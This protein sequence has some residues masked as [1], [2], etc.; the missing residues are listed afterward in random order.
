[1]I[2]FWLIA[3]LLVAG[4]LAVLLRP[5]LRDTG[6]DAD[7][8]E[9]VAAMYRRQ[10]AELDAEAAQGRLDGADATAAR[11]ELM[12][13]ML[14]AAD[15]PEA[16]AAVRR[17]A[18][19]RVGAAVGIAGAVPASALAIY[20]AVGMPGAIKGA[21]DMAAHDMADLSAAAAR[22]QQHLDGDPGDV[23]GWTLLGRTLTALDRP[24]DAAEAFRHAVALAPGDPQLHAEFGQALTL[25]AKGTIT[26]E[27]AAQFAKSP[28]DPRSRYFE[29]EAAMQRGDVAAAKAGLTA[30]L[31]DTP[32][33]APWRQ[34]VATRLQQIGSGGEP[35][36]TAADAEAA[37]KMPADARL[38]MIRGM[39]GRLE[40][41]LDAHPDD[42]QGW[43]MLA[44]SYQVLGR[45]ADA[46]TALQRA[47]AD[48][49][50]NLDLMRAYLATLGDGVTG[51]QLP[52]ELVALATRVNAL[53][54]NDPPALWYL[55]LAA[56][57]RGDK[58]AATGYWRHLLAE[59]PA[60]DEAKRSLVQQRLD[61]LRWP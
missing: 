35:G 49:P 7:A 46:R 42:P 4:V 60:D 48:N 40:A 59:L 43:I 51:D 32:K 8:G 44:R 5:L 23:S 6:S 14:A 50:N 21:P 28:N 2:L 20:L 61:T 36:P 52:P 17:G 26:A 9:P 27:A 37:E 38:T 19:W 24:A 34:L 41:K 10:L 18:A 56:A 29:A 1:V 45:G 39:V 11:A 25:A 58:A 13:R 22:L 31:A 33:D 15:A 16:A 47:N 53:D 30:L 55:G 54:G 57:A 12:R 3:A